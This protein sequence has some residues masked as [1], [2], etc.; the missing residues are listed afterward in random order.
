M[1]PTGIAMVPADEP[2][3]QASIERLACL[4]RHWAWAE[5]AKV[6][7]DRE[8]ADGWD[9]EEDLAAD[10]PF[11]SFYHW[12]ALLSGFAQAALD[13][14][15]LSPSLLLGIRKDLEASLPELQACR[16]VLVTIPSSMESHPLVIELLRD[17]PRLERLR[18]LHAAFGDAVRQEQVTRDVE[19]LDH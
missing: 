6:R 19:L 2:L 3:R 5:E 16:D 18:R 13:R 15:L 14:Q 9:Y 7:F 8:L 1:T 17:E 11:G 12:C 10:R 4:V